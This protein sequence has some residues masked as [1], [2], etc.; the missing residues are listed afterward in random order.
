MAAAYQTGVASSPVNLLQTL[1][2][3]LSTQGWTT[4]QSASSGSGWRAHLHKNG[5][6][7]NLRAAMNENIWPALSG[8]NQESNLGYGIGL[9]LGDG[10]SGAAAWSA[11]SG[12]PTRTSDASTQGSGMNLYAGAVA[13]YHFFD[14]GADHIT[15][16]IEKS[17][18]LFVHLGWGPTMVKTGFSADFPYF[19]A[20][21]SIYR[22]LVNP[23]GFGN[24]GMDLTA[25]CPIAHSVTEFVAGPTAC[26]AN[27]FIRV[28]AATFSGRWISNVASDTNGNYYTGRH[29]RCA[30]N[31][32]GSTSS[33]HIGEY[34][35]YRFLSGRIHQVAYTGALLLPLH[36]FC[37][38][39]PSTRWAP[40][41]YPPS[42]FWTEAV[43]HG[44]AAGEVYQVGGLD[45]ML[46]P[47]FAVFKGA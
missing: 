26:L 40:V 11:Q 38:M 5:L 20:S 27:A 41:G 6:Y 46:F 24:A 3:F 28:D 33:L 43:G 22:N 32:Q 19:F 15:V 21:S 17:P 36:S 30:L 8:G 47:D 25:D 4:D 9:Y 42:V 12:R 31:R 16:V 23:Q 18:G 13:A 7:V 39:D 14:N 45:Y 10:Y 37:K 29:M 1:V 34:P 44:F 2:S 35:N